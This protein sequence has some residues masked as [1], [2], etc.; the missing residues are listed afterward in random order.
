MRPSTCLSSPLNV[1][2]HVSLTVLILKLLVLLGAAWIAHG[3]HRSRWNLNGT[4]DRG[5]GDGGQGIHD[6]ACSGVHDG[7]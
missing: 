1:Y 3:L 2:L 4:G 5:I 6:K 7:T